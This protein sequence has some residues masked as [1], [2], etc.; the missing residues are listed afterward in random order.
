MTLAGSASSLSLAP[1]AR[2]SLSQTLSRSSSLLSRTSLSLLC[3]QVHVLPRATRSQSPPARAA[4]R[5][6]HLH[7]AACSQPELSHG[8]DRAPDGVRLPANL[9][10]VQHTATTTS[11]SSS[12]DMVTPRPGHW[13]ARIGA[14][15]AGALCSE[16]GQ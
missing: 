12:R 13:H 3:V 16:R 14:G 8:Q 15:S 5:L 1:T 7:L 2:L 9:S 6:T 4:A 10:H 11:S